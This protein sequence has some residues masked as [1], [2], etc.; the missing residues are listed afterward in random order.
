MQ[1]GRGTAMAA[2]RKPAIHSGFRAVADLRHL[3]VGHGPL[4]IK[5]LRGHAELAVDVESE[6][7]A[8][9]GTKTLAVHV[10]GSAA[11]PVAFTG[12]GAA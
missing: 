9:S 6:E 7:R 4:C 2:L 5:V 1:G 8:L 12:A 3:G 11:T 10:S